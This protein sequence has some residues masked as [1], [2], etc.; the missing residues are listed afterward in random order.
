MKRAYKINYAQENDFQRLHRDRSVSQARAQPA[1]R[2]S[3]VG[4]LAGGGKP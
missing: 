2:T 3:R 1:R 4:S